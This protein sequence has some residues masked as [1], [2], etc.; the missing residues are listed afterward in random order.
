MPSFSKLLFLAATFTTLSAS[1]M[2]GGLI[3]VD[4]GAFVRPV[5]V[6]LIT[7]QDLDESL[8][9]QGPTSVVFNEHPQEVWQILGG[10]FARS[11]P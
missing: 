2:E 11:R 5:F 3:A 4:P 9:R 8:S 10:R 7:A 6:R 1:G